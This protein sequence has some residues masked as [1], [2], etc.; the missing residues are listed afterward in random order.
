MMLEA[1]EKVIEHRLHN[2]ELVKTLRAFLIHAPPI[3]TRNLK[4][5]NLRRNSSD[6]FVFDDYDQYLG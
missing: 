4:L 5:G 6:N 1:H 3:L 2:V